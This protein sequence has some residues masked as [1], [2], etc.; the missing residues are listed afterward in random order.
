MKKCPPNLSGKLCITISTVAEIAENLCIGCGQCVKRCPFKAIQIINLP[1]ELSS[2][3]LV[4]QY[5]KNSFR[6]YNL[7]SPKRGEILGLIGI[8]G[9][10]KSTAINLLTNTIPNL[11]DFLKMVIKNVS[12]GILEE[13]NYKIIIHQNWSVK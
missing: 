11:G 6:L 3:M 4:H 2:K 9:I 8:N 10:G 5:S 1:S 13:M 7:P 12:L